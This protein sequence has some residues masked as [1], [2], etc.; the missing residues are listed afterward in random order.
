MIMVRYEKLIYQPEFNVY[1][2]SC[3]AKSIVKEKRKTYLYNVL[4]TYYRY[5][6]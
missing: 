4:G 6:K 1:L 3:Y 5:N 2:F